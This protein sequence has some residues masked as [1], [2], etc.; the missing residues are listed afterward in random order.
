MKIKLVILIL[1][2]CMGSAARTVRANT[3]PALLV[4]AEAEKLAGIREAVT[5]PFP[6]LL[7]V[8]QVENQT[9]DEKYRQPYHTLCAVYT[10][11]KAK[12]AVIGYVLRFRVYAPNAGSL[13]LARRAARLL[14]L[15]HG[16][17]R[18]RLGY[19]H[20]KTLPVIDV[21]LSGQ[22]GAGLS[23]DIGGEQFGS[24]IYIYR[25]F[26]ERSPAEWA[27]E[28][29]HEYGHF[30][31]P[32]VTGFTEPEAW[33][34]GVLGE[35]LFLLWLQEDLERPRLQPADIPFVTPPELAAYCEKQCAPLIRRI[36]QYGP[37][38]KAMARRDAADMEAF[39]GLA[40]YCDTVYGSRGLR[41][42][43]AYTESSQGDS[44]LRA[45]DFLRGMASSLQ[46]AAE[47]TAALPCP[48]ASAKQETFY[49]LLPKGAWTAA[50]SDSI[51]RREVDGG[52]KSEISW[53]KTGLEVRQSGWHKIT[54]I[55][56]KT[57]GRPLLLTFRKRETK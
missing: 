10:A 22:A 51:S 32:G 15:L 14:L 33:A 7:F 17:N 40:L 9:S 48:D 46:S 50:A 27:R 6:G 38:T 47:W 25:I 42:A 29:A 30:A 3:P 52:A 55:R 21:W 56:A 39:V 49:L 28:I 12:D 41:N 34:N 5:G 2:M 57:N 45:P 16:E 1:L 13:P 43:F 24:Q 20:P 53:T 18:E 37:D 4:P 35:R 26:A 44:F 54:L 23:S 31:L 8:P 19:E 36:A 11:E